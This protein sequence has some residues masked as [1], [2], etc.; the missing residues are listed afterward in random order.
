MKIRVDFGTLGPKRELSFY[1][2]I[3]A[4]PNAVRFENEKY[5]WVMYDKDQTKQYDYILVFALMDPLDSRWW[6]CVDF[7]ERFGYNISESC[8]CGSIYTSYAAGH[9]FYCSLWRKV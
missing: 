5:E 7:S 6:S 3:S 8:S 4:F 2:D 1:Q 9:M